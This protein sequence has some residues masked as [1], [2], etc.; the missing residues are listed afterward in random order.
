MEG[1]K[2]IRKKKDKGAKQCRIN[3]MTERTGNEKERS[4]QGFILSV[5]M[6]GASKTLKF[7]WLIDVTLGETPKSSG[8]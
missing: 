5:L 2:E 7:F 3:R 1:K 6:P 8:P 4:L